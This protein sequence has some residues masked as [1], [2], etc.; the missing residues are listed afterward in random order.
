MPAHKNIVGPQ[1]RRFREQRGWSQN[2]FAAKCQMA[3]WD[4]SR[5]IVAAIEGRVRWVGDFE[6]ML[7]AKVLRINP[8]ELLPRQLA[9]SE[10]I[11][12]R[13][14]FYSFVCSETFKM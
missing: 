2:A 8:I 11:L 13:I 14:K 5:G 10:L 1:A 6:L 4:I 12:R 3:G 9:M 7:V